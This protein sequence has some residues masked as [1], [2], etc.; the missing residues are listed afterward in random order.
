MLAGGGNCLV[1]QHP[2][3]GFLE[4][5]G[6]VGCVRLILLLALVVKVID[7]R[8]FQAAK[9]EIEAGLVAQIGAG[10]LHRL[11]PAPQGKAVNPGP[12]GVTQAH[13]PGHLVKSFTGGI[14]PGLSQ[15]H[16]VFRRRHQQQGGMAAGGDERHQRIADSGTGKK[17]GIKVSLHMVDRDQRQPGRISERF[18]RGDA[19]D[20]RSHQAGAVGDGD[21]VYPL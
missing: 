18:C 3:E 8:R 6:Q 5:G 17:I 15:G 14:I 7:H 4:R 12:P 16:N 2:D 21:G 13:R 9:A 1:H 11:P 19:H 20:Q 10:K